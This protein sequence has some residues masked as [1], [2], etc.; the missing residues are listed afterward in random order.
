MI[1]R[2]WFVRGAA[3]VAKNAK[4]RITRI[5]I[6]AHESAISTHTR[7]KLGDDAHTPHFLPYFP[8]K[9]EKS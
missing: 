5:F 3:S 1:L 7:E 2:G 8:I 4:K 9:L 6:S